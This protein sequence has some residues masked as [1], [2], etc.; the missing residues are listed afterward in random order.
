MPGP[1]TDDHVKQISGI[2]PACQSLKDIVLASG[3]SLSPNSWQSLATAAAATTSTNPEL[4]MRYLKRDEEE[5]WSLQNT[6]LEFTSMPAEEFMKGILP[7][8]S[9]LGI[10]NLSSGDSEEMLR[11]LAELAPTHPT[12]QNTA[13]SCPIGSALFCALAN[14]GPITLACD[15][16]LVLTTSDLT[17]L[18]LKTQQG[19]VV[20]ERLM[21]AVKKAEQDGHKVSL[22]AES[23]HF[24]IDLL[25]AELEMKE[26]TTQQLPVLFC[27]SAA[28][29][30]LQSPDLGR[31]ELRAAFKAAEGR[32]AKGEDFR[33]HVTLGEV[34]TWAHQPTDLP[35]QHTL[36]V[37]GD[38]HPG[39]QD[40]KNII[41]AFRHFD[42]LHRILC[43]SFG[44]GLSR[45]LRGS[46]TCSRGSPSDCPL[47]CLC[48]GAPAADI[49]QWLPL[50]PEELDLQLRI[51]SQHRGWGLSACFSGQST[52][53]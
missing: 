13:L 19:R 12:L 4:K 31:S 2:L 16:S 9:S 7:H 33:L 38:G 52:M 41:R 50:V 21:K 6:V 43:L 49:I 48:S 53:L 34:P 51:E 24:T 47:A 45:K 25:A 8:L 15:A 28:N 18:D 10:R 17:G 37:S 30:Y 26:V 42:N 27:A 5:C 44:H 3:N 22:N 35:K 23:G 39:L 14:L 20:L 40:A 11:I 32:R 1:L 46:W 36:R 29:I